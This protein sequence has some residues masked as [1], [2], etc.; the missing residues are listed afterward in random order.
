VG[1]RALHEVEVLAAEP[2]NLRVGLR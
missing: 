2:R 1:E